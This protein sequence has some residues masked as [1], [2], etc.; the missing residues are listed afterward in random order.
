MGT[1]IGLVILVAIDWYLV[2]KKG[3]HI[4][5]WISKKY[6]VYLSEKGNKK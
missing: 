4:H 2:R 1:V 3:L 5:N 6:A